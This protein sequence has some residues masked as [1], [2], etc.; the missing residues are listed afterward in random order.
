M[1]ISVEALGDAVL[2]YAGKVIKLKST[3]L[4]YF[5]LTVIISSGFPVAGRFFR[6]IIAP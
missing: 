5:P 1:L 3:H 6:A 2:M 4:E